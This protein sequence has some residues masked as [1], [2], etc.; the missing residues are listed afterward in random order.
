[1]DY[2]VSWS[3][4][5]LDDVEAIAEHIERDSPAYARAVVHKL[6][7]S[8]RNL[9]TFPRTGRVV[10][11]LDDEAIGEVFVYSYPVF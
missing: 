3:P 7:A 11:E 9:A 10:P 2:R 4:Q 6:L 5:V 1:M 8:T